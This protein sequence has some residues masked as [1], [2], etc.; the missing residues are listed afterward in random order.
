MKGGGCLLWADAVAD[1]FEL[2]GAGD[3]GH[4]G[5]VPFGEAHKPF[6]ECRVQ[7]GFSVLVRLGGGGCGHAS[8]LLPAVDGRLV[9]A[10]HGL[11]SR[12]DGNV[13]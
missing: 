13:G 4:L 12:E 6:G 3:A 7:T 5:D 10:E 2:V 1:G 11:A 9:L 8:D